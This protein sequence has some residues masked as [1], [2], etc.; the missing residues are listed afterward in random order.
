MITSMRNVAGIF[1]GQGAQAVGMGFALTERFPI[2]RETFA[3]ADETLGFSLSTLCFEGPAEELKRTSIAQ[4]ALLAV[5]IAYWR[6]LAAQGFSCMVMAGHSLG[7]YSALTAAGA[8]AFPDA[9]RLVRRRG[10]LME[11]AALAHPGG[12]AAV[13]GLSDEEVVDLCA[14][15]AARYGTLA[16]ANYNA[17]GQIVVSGVAEALTALRAAGKSRGARV[18][19]L[20]VSG[21]FHSPLMADAATAF[22]A[23]LDAVAIAIPSVPVVPNVT[24]TPTSDPVE[25]REALA[26]QITGSVRWVGSVGAMQELGAQQFCRNWARQCVDRTRATGAA[27]RSR[28]AGGRVADGITPRISPDM[29]SDLASLYEANN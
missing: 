29:D 25:L 12:M 2:A 16:P 27:G 28:P 8:L 11:E 13:I 10:E 19:P 9:L 5:S 3:Q 22:R 4:P 17:P 23:V 21:P 7:E 24:A 14:E 1:P 15:T 20:A 26:R 18:I 6:V